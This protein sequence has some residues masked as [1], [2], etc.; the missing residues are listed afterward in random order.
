MP[1]VVRGRGAGAMCNSMSVTD[2][3]LLGGASAIV[4]TTT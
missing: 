1:A 4:P 3:P 2:V